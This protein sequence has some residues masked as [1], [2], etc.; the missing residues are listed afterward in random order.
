MLAM[1]N[2]YPVHLY[3]AIMFY[4]PE[5]CGGDGGDFET[6]GWWSVAPGSCANVYANDLE[7]L[8][9]Y[10]YYYAEADDGAVWAGPWRAYV[11]DEAFN[12]CYGKGISTWYRV[13]MR[14][15]DIGDND[16]FTLTFV[17]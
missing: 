1:C 12:G 5:T 8:N 17:P 15:L 7:D 9:R 13:G 10:W 6:M 3:V 2:G 4:S 16:D 14:E 11:T